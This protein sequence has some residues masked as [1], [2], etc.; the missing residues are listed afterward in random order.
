M[1][2]VFELFVSKSLKQSL[3]WAL[4]WHFLCFFWTQ[5]VFRMASH[6]LFKSQYQFS[7]DRWTVGN[8]SVQKYRMHKPIEH[9][10]LLWNAK[11]GLQTSQDGLK[12]MDCLIMIMIGKEPRLA[13]TSQIQWHSIKQ[14]IEVT[15][16][17]ILQALVIK[18]HA[19]LFQTQFRQQNLQFEVTR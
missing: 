1:F 6:S 3:N 7:V 17:I 13:H 11:L 5:E 18:Y 12:T 9:R 16:K 2:E 14:E 4:V 8:S 10:S 15:L 19:G